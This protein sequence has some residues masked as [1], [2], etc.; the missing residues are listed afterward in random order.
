[1]SEALGKAVHSLGGREGGV[2]GSPT[3][4]RHAPVTRGSLGSGPR[5]KS[6]PRETAGWRER[7]SP[8]SGLRLAPAGTCGGLHGG[9]VCTGDPSLHLVRLG[10]PQP[11][12]PA[13]P[14]RQL[15][16]LSSR[17]RGA[18]RPRAR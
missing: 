1:M 16:G 3:R 15:R 7:R 9:R 10:P 13:A 18:R 17:D 2:P 5:P 8:G 12:Q 4:P 14:V 11:P 6:R